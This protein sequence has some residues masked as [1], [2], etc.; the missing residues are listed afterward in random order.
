MVF[1]TYPLRPAEPESAS[2]SSWSAACPSASITA[3]DLHNLRSNKIKQSEPQTLALHGSQNAVP[4][5]SVLQFRPGFFRIRHLFIN[6]AKVKGSLIRYHLVSYDHT[7]T[8]VGVPPRAVLRQ[9]KRPENEEADAAQNHQHHI[10]GAQRFG[11][12]SLM[13]A[14]SWAFFANLGLQE[15]AP[16]T[17]R[18]SR[19]QATPGVGITST[20]PIKVKKAETEKHRRWKKANLHV[21][22]IAALTTIQGGQQASSWPLQ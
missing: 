20:P 8:N 21:V 14:V 2:G 4:T 17:W 11:Q 16:N 13:S 6:P 3:E 1:I 9:K 22:G 18:K 5:T 7:F 10:L 15:T 12:S 19:F